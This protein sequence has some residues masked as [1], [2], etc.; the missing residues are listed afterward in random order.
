APFVSGEALLTFNSQVAPAL[1]N[2]I[3]PDQEKNMTALASK[4]VEG[5]LSSLKSGS[6]RII[7][8]E[9]LARRLNVS[10]GDK[11]TVVTPEMSLTPAGVLPR[12]KRFTVIGIFN[13]GSGFGFDAAL[14]Y[15]H[16]ADA[17]KLYGAGNMVTC[18]HLSLENVFQAPEMTQMLLSKL[19][20]SAYI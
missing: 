14:A 8:G 6:F 16:L 13:A 20:S 7:L 4:V 17:Q 9:E 19:S 10:V 12:F 3:I 18:I 1:V 5:K 15:T 11:V 2:G